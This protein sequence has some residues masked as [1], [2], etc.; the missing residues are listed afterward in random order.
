MNPGLAAVLIGILLLLWVLVWT[1][2]VGFGAL[3]SELET[4]P[5][6]KSIHEIDREL[7]TL[8]KRANGPINSTDDLR[9]LQEDVRKAAADR[10][11]MLT[12]ATLTRHSVGSRS[13]QLGEEP[14]GVVMDDLQD[15]P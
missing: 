1:V 14:G 3:T 8:W 7:A 12:E 10:G 4:R 6:R 2:R 5:R 15:W 9:A 13:V 11:V